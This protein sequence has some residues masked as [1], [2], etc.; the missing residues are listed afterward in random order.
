MEAT[1]AYEVD[2]TGTIIQNFINS[3]GAQGIIG[4]P[5]AQG[6]VQHHSPNSSINQSCDQ[7]APGTSSEEGRS[8]L[9]IVVAVVFLIVGVA[10]LVLAIVGTVTWPAFLG[11]VA[12]L[13]FLTTIIRLAFG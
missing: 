12:V 9:W 4:S 6:A 7:A 3:P 5:G 10:A 8:W 1:H 11:V 13:G 2:A